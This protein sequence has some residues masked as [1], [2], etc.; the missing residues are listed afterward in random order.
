MIEVRNDLWVGDGTDYEEVKKAK[1][2]EWAIVQAAKEPYHREALEYT[3]NAA[4]KDNPEYLF[5][6]RDGLSKIILN[7]VDADDPKYFQDKMVFAA[8]A[9]IDSW[10]GLRKVLIHCNKGES[11]AP[12][13]AMLWMGLHGELD[14]N[15]VIAHMKFIEKYPKFDPRPG[16]RAYL[17]TKWPNT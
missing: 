10:M 13:L 2:G 16:M 8:I 9:F 5:A 14:D 15:F 3:G 4:P 12:G 6:L 11:R 7:M 17:L 1:E